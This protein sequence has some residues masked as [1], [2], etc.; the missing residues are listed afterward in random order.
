MDLLVERLR[1]HLS[2]RPQALLALLLLYIE[3]V[4]H[5]GRTPG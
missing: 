4:V 1:Y 3:R 5:T 2:T